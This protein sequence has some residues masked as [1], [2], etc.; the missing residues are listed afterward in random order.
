MRALKESL[1][2]EDD[3]PDNDEEELVDARLA[4]EVPGILWIC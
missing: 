3:T 2:L 4:Y 1:E